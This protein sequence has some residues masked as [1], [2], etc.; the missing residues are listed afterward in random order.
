MSIWS[1]VF[2][3]FD[4]VFFMF[5]F[6]LKILVS[7]R[8]FRQDNFNVD[9]LR[10]VMVIFLEFFCLCDICNKNLYYEKMVWIIEVE[11][12]NILCDI[13]GWYKCEFGMK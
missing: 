3:L 13:K 5:V 11:V 8:N 9:D 10:G 1:K 12:E 4:V 6:F 7:F 2:L